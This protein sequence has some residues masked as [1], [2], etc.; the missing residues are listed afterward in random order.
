VGKELGKVDTSSLTDLR[1]GTGNCY[2]RELSAIFN[3]VL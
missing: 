2:S 3:G 1:C